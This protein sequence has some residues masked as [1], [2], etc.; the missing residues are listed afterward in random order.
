[1]L[2]IV[3]EFCG[4]IGFVEMF[5]LEL[6]VVPSSWLKILGN[7]KYQYLN[8]VVGFGLLVCIGLLWLLTACE[9]V[10]SICW[11]MKVLET[12]QNFLSH[13]VTC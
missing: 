7:K 11:L 2:E 12:L 13:P 8:C 5:A 3:R 4:V 9:Y 6:F 1:M 10:T